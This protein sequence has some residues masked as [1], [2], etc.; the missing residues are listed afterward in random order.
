M[1]GG[2]ISE[3][4]S[5]SPTRACPRRS[6]PRRPS[7]LWKAALGNKAYGGP[8]IAGGKVYVGTNNEQPRN[9]RDVNKTT[10]IPSTRAS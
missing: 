9:K 10:A 7:V 4:W 2:T 5:T 1:F 3:T 8:I 6:R